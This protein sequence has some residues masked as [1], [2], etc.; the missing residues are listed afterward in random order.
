MRQCGEDLH[1]PD[2]SGKAGR[3][4]ELDMATI[5]AIS[6]ANLGIWL[7]E[8]PYAH[9]YF[10]YYAPTLVHLD[11]VPGL[12]PAAL[13][14]EGATHE[15]VMGAL[16]PAT[17]DTVDPRDH[18]TLRTLKIAHVQEQLVLP[19]HDHAREVAKRAIQAVINGSL[20]A[21]DPGDHWGAFFRQQEIAQ[22]QPLGLL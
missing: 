19:S 15:F 14:R 12:P 4:W 8:A 21:A 11:E 18:T 7:I 1:N 9:P 3:A 2:F 6:P 16:D 10:N 17:E 13:V 20:P 22:D 5:T